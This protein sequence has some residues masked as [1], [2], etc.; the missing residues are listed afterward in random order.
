MRLK[1]PFSGTEMVIIFN[2]RIGKPEHP[3]GPSSA[4]MSRRI[5]GEHRLVYKVYD[6]RLHIISCRFHYNG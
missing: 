4:A 6:E 5:D 1:R 3:K 2:L